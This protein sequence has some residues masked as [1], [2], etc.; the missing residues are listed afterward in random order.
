MD[1]LTDIEHRAPE[2]F[3]SRLRAQVLS[4]FDGSTEAEVVE[5]TTLR[6]ST[7]SRRAKSIRPLAIA[8]VVV[9]IVGLGALWA[10]LDEPAEEAD[11]V[12]GRDGPCLDFLAEAPPAAELDVTVAPAVRIEALREME[13]A[14]VELRSRLASDAATSPDDLRQLRIAAGAFREARLDLEAGDATGSEAAGTLGMET[15]AGLESIRIGVDEGRLTCE[16][17]DTA[18]P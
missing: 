10:G 6:Q 18:V 12:T 9:V 1:E 13:A 7:A 4:E 3:R 14:V 17:T 8:A 15:I 5:L 2:P 16:R 11:V